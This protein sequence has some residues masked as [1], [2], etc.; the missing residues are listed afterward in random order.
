MIENYIQ[1]EIRYEV[2]CF[3][4]HIQNLFHSLSLSLLLLSIAIDWSWIWYVCRDC[5]S[6]TTARK[7]NHHTDTTPQILQDLFGF[8]SLEFFKA[9]KNQTQFFSLFQAQYR[10]KERKTLTFA[11]FYAVFFGLASTVFSLY[12]FNLWCCQ[13]RIHILY[14]QAW[15]F[16]WIELFCGL[17]DIDEAREPAKD[18]NGEEERSLTYRNCVQL[19]FFRRLIELY[20]QK[21]TIT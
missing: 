15:L 21:R 9:K 1:H 20:I 18:E 13:C 6:W 16:Y 19:K 14:G 10:K 3:C 7:S 2:N 11:H 8:F 17:N 5:E 12:Q 4:V